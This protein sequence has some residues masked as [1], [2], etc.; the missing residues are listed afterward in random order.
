MSNKLNKRK[1]K[2]KEGIIAKN[3][4]KIKIKV[5]NAKEGAQLY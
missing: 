1:K 2:I 4:K 5:E 3:G